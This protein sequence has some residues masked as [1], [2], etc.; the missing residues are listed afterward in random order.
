MTNSI[1]FIRRAE[2]CRLTHATNSTLRGFP[3]HDI[4]TQPRLYDGLVPAL[5]SRMLALWQTLTNMREAF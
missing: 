2:T 3:F 1:S 5:I 4:D